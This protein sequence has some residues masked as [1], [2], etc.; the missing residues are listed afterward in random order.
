[1]RVAGARSGGWRRA[2]RRVVLL[3][4]LG[5]G[6]APEGSAQARA[7]VRGIVRDD[8]GRPLVGAR[9]LV[10]GSV[11]PVEAESDDEGELTLAGLPVGPATMVARRIGF[12]PETLRVSVAAANPRALEWRLARV[13]TSIDPV[14]VFGRR[15]LSGGVAGFYRRREQGNG[16]FFTLEQIERRNVRRMTDLLR[17]IPGMRLEQRRPGQ[18]QLRMR[19]STAPPLVWLDGAPMSAGEVDLDSFDP[20]SF[21]G[22]EIYSGAATVP[23]QFSGGRMMSSSGGAIVLWTRRG[24]AGPP[25]RRRGPTA[26]ETIADLLST[27]EAFAAEAVDTPARPASDERITPVYPD[28]LFSAGVGGRV[29]IEFVVDAAGRVRMD[30]F[31]VIT[32]SHPRWIDPVRR[33]IQPVVFVPAVRGGRPVAQ[34]V[35]LPFEFVPDSTV[36]VRKPED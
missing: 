4:C 13:A 28:S 27:G 17:G 5:G 34:L 31:G 19:G 25:R 12:A 14:M 2:V 32:T 36:A 22:I 3:T 18:S 33:A 23:A 8:A 29:E 9:V 16:R 7:A 1:M 26:A 30:T 15:D 11:P 10:I 24:Q 35:Q 20:R 6:V 21:E